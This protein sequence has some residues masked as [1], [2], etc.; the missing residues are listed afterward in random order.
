M[1]RLCEI[2]KYVKTA[3]FERKLSLSIFGS[4]TNVGAEFSEF[5]SNCVSDDIFMFLSAKIVFGHD[6]QTTRYQ[7]FLIKLL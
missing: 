7:S 2:M 3:V 4:K 1:T 5:R 6:K